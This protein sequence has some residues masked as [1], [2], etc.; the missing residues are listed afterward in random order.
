MAPQYAPS[1]RSRLAPLLLFLQ[2]G[3]IIIFAFYCELDSYGTKDGKTFSDF[4]AEFQDVNVMVILGFGFLCTFLVRYGFSGSGFNLLVAAMAT[5]WAIILNGIES[6]YERGKIRIDL[7]SILVAEMCTASALISIGTVLGKTNPVHL[8]LI[9]LLEVSGFVLNEWVLLT[10]LKVRPLNGI[11]L[12][13]IFGAF[14]GLTLT[15]ILYRK[16]SEEGF[17]KEKFDRKSGL[18]SMLGTLFLWMF[19]PSFNSILVNS[20]TPLRK[21]WAVCGTYLALAVSAVTAAAVSVLSSPLGKLN[22][23]QMQSSILAGGVAVGVSMPVI[24]LPWEAMAIGFT[25]AIMSTI[26]FKYLKIHMLLAFESHD[27]CAALSTH[28]LPGLLGWLVHLLLQIKDFDNY[29]V[30]IRFAVFHICT[31]LVTIAISLSTGILTGFLLKWNFWRPSPN[32]KCFD[33][34]AFWEFPHNAVRK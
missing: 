21:D 18:F 32:K 5:Q 30:A 28:G 27:T 4:Y 8:I 3:F 26:G 6:W 17:E 9:A 33:D 7:K 12:L 2:T 1:L 19:W 25:A 13:H 29:T 16:G 24:Q 23:I 22:L 31:L 14:F 11:M 20:H 15:W 10:L 34:Q